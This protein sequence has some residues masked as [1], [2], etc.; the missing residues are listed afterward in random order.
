MGQDTVIKVV[1]CIV[2]AALVIAFAVGVIGRSNNETDQL[3]N[4]TQGINATV[5]G[6]IGELAAE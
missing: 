2:I 1:G 6:A 4:S 5:T 3:H